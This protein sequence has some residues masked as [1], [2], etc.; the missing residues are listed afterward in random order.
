MLPPTRNPWLASPVSV[1]RRKPISGEPALPADSYLLCRRFEG[2]AG[3]EQGGVG[4]DVLLVERFF[5]LRGQGRIFTYLLE[6]V[7]FASVQGEQGVERGLPGCRE[8]RK[9]SLDGHAVHLDFVYFEYRGVAFLQSFFEKCQQFSGI[10]AALFEQSGSTFLVN[11]VEA[12]AFGLQEQVAACSGVFLPEHFALQPGCLAACGV[13]GGEVE[14]LAD[15]ELRA[16]HAVGA[17]AEEGAVFYGECFGIV[18]SLELQLCGFAVFLEREERLVV[19]LD[20][21]QCSGYVLGR[22]GA[23]GGEQ[24]Q[25]EKGLSHGV[26]L[27]RVWMPTAGGG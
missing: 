19:L 4:G 9:L 23:D 20:A 21:L 12:E 11:H 10:H 7:G 5:A 6:G 2:G 16:G 27:W 8:L 18:G 1:L 24:R 17:A 26:I 15:D 14:T 25:E 13:E 22:Q 3:C